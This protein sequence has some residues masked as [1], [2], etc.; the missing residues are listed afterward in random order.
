MMIVD[1]FKMKKLVSSPWFIT[2][3][4]ASRVKISL[5]FLSFALEKLTLNLNDGTLT[6]FSL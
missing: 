1:D 4:S 2:K 3:L 6:S 5:T